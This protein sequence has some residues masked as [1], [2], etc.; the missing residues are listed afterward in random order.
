M[1]VV[2]VV[3][4]KNKLLFTSTIVLLVEVR[5]KPTSSYSQLFKR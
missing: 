2:L 4:I 3:I 5:Y 1:S